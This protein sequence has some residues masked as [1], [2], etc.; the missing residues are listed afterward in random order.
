MPNREY[1]IAL[2]YVRQEYRELYSCAEAVILTPASRFPTGQLGQCSPDNYINVKDD[3][4]TV[5]EYVDT[6]V[7]ELTHA[8]QN[9]RGGPRMS[10]LKREEEAYAAGLKAAEDYLIKAAPWRKR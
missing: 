8:H 6:L 2:Q 3:L 5:G 4:S 7:H 9:K 10:D 1:A